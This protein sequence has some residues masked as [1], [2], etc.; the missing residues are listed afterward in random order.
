M[1]HETDGTRVRFCLH[2]QMGKSSVLIIRNLAQQRETPPCN[3]G[4][5]LIIKEKHK[6][7]N[8]QQVGRDATPTKHSRKSV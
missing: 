3:K 5:H 2:V 6:E 4:F 8:C 1:K 7:Q